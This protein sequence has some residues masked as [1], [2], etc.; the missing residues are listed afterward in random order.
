MNCITYADGYW[1]AGV[2]SGSRYTY[3]VYATSLSENWLMQD[4][5]LSNNE[6]SCLNCITHA[7]GYW[8]VGGRHDDTTACIAYATALNGTWTTKDLW[9]TDGNTYKSCVNCITY[10]DGH[11]VVG[12]RHS[13][14][15]GVAHACVGYTTTLDGTWKEKTLWTGYQDTTAV[16][17]ILYHGGYW[18]AFGALYASSATA[19]PGTARIANATVLNSAWTAKDVWEC[20]GAKAN[21]IAFADDTCVL[22]GAAVEDQADVYYGTGD[23]YLPTVAHEGAYTYVKASTNEEG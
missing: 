12:G 4:I 9:E 13:D 7:D 10:A 20:V 14:D 22:G 3:V 16:Q 11:W 19:D 18:T 2:S 21:F 8:V 6:T 17:D 23:A 1:V 15:D 5:W